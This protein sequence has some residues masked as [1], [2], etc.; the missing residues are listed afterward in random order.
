MATRVP[1]TY[2][3]GQSIENEQSQNKFRCAWLEVLVQD[4]RSR[5]QCPR[6]EGTIDVEFYMRSVMCFVSVCGF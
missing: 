2:M 1:V 6:Y 4:S 5:C 3:G